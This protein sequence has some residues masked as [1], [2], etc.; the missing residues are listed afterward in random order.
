MSLRSYQAGALHQFF[1]GS[2]HRD[3]WS[4]PIVA[5]E[6]DLS[7]YAGGLTPTRRGGGLQTRS[8]RFD[9]EEGPV[10][11]FRSI[12][13]DATRNLDPQLQE[14][15][16]ATV[17]Q[18]Q[19]GAL[20][21][22]S[23]MVV[24]PLL[25]ATDVLHATPELVVLPDSPLL[26][27]F[28]EDYA[29]LV[30]W[31][32]VRPDE[33]P[34][35]EPAFAGADRVTSTPTFLEH[36]ED[37]PK[38]RVDAAAFLRARLM[39]LYVGDWDRHPDQWRWA[40][41]EEG[42]DVTLW[43]PI[44][45]DRDWA[46]NNINGL[47]WTL[48]RRTIP[49]YVS[50]G[51]E[52]VSVF[53]T[54]WNGRALDRQLLSG[55]SWQDWERTVAGLQAALS[56]ELIASAVDVLPAGFEDTADD[57][58]TALRARRDGLMEAAKEYYDL[59]ATRVDV[60]A[61]DEPELAHVERRTDGSVHVTVTELRRGRVLADAP[62]FERTFLPSETGGVRLYLRGARDSVVVEGPLGDM[63][64]RAIGGGGDDTFR[65]L[66]TGHRTG[67]YDDR[68]D[69]VF[70]PAGD[71]E[72]DES[73]YEEPDD[74]ESATHQA[75]PRDWGSRWIAYP[76][77]GAN[78]DVGA[79]LGQ[80][81]SWNRYGFR[82]FPYRQQLDLNWILN[83]VNFGFRVG[84]TLRH[85]LSHT[86]EREWITSV[87]ATSRTVRYYHGIGNDRQLVGD[88][89]FHRSDRA[90]GELKTGMGFSGT[91]S[92]VETG[93][94][95][96][97]TRPIRSEDGRLVQDEEPA[98]FPEAWRTGVYLNATVDRRDS[99]VAP[100]RGGMIDLA[101]HLTPALLD[102]PGAY[103]SIRGG[104]SAS[105]SAGPVV[106]TGYSQAERVVGDAPFFELATL[107]GAG[108]LRG[109]RQDRFLGD[110]LL[111]GGAEVRF[112]VIPFFAFFPGTLGLSGFAEAGRVYSD[113]DGVAV[114]HTGTAGTGEAVSEQ[115]WH[116]SYGGGVWISV[117]SSEY[118]LNGTLARSEEGNR[119]YFG[120]GFAR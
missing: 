94:S 68:G 90:G 69:N 1:L 76:L 64:V 52:Y 114:A 49:Q 27:E 88:S 23:A 70:V 55:L 21:P 17:L 39:D 51:P 89:E 9:S 37:D 8:L 79:F 56:N 36:L 112:P 83:P 106:L 97:Y 63:W 105:T 73:D 118:T 95:L 109:F 42:D 31:I 61:T 29:D 71:T 100:T 60:F 40:A 41:F 66:T 87:D 3:L 82:R 33:G 20:F 34:D 99:P 108:S 5:P 58:A 113:F 81:Q 14:S 103:G 62:F 24:A 96:R 45:R 107:G 104:L 4:I 117:V 46:L 7:R 116:A 85:N 35:G 59:T 50:F 19:I 47:V 67:F 26:G 80:T 102:A 57:L 53:G 30:G 15:L 28:R 25:E 54:V 6:L 110:G 119:F 32:E 77:L 16:A 2:L 84:A 120:L 10:Y 44:P 115:G 13:K 72:V 91:S 11:T 78:Q 43:Y 48:V 74:T 75:R 12:E 22:L 38:D 65:D 92:H 98:G 86:A 101:L 93:V 18:D 111:L